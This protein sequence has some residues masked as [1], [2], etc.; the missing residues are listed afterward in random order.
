MISSEEISNL[1]IKACNATPLF[2]FLFIT[3]NQTSPETTTFNPYFS[4]STNFGNTL[5]SVGSGNIQNDVSITLDMPN[6]TDYNTFVTQ[7]QRDT[8][9]ENIV[10]AMTVDQ[11]SGKNTLTKLK[12]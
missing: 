1:F 4:K 9:F 10:K 12:Y 5:N 8:R 11:L 2:D 7:L 3:S 6:V